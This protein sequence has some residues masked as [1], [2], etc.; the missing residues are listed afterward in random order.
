MNTTSSQTPKYLSS[1]G[2]VDSINFL[3]PT[4]RSHKKQA[5]ESAIY[6]SGSSSTRNLN[7]KQ[8]S[9][10][11]TVMEEVPKLQDYMDDL[12]KTWNLNIDLMEN[13]VEADISLYNPELKN[14]PDAVKHK[15]I[16]SL[17]K[18]I[19]QLHDKKLSM[20]KKTLTLR[21]KLLLDQQIEEEVKKTLFES[22]K[23]YFDQEKELEDL[24]L[25]KE[26]I[27][28][29]NEKKFNEVEIYI[30]RECL[31]EE[32]KKYHKYKDFFV[33]PF[34]RENQE[35]S[36]KR[37]LL[38]KYINTKLNEV[39]DLKQENSRLITGDTPKKHEELL[40]QSNYNNVNRVIK[41]H[42]SNNSFAVKLPI[43]TP[44]SKNCKTDRKNITPNSKQF[45]SGLFYK[46]THNNKFKSGENEMIVLVKKQKKP[47]HERIKELLEKKILYMS[48]L[49]EQFKFSLNYYIEKE[50]LLKENNFLI[51]ALINKRRGE[52]L[53]KQ[54]NMEDTG[55]NQLDLED[56]EKQKTIS[57]TDDQQIKSSVYDSEKTLFK[58]IINDE[59]SIILKIQSNEK[60]ISQIADNINS[61]SEKPLMNMDKGE[62]Y[63]FNNMNNEK[64][65]DNYIKDNIKENINLNDISMNTTVIYHNIN[66]KPCDNN[67]TIALEESFITKDINFNTNNVNNADDKWDISV[68]NTNYYDN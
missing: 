38:V 67:L 36:Y 58:S 63:T 47:K 52:G 17:I 39:E 27:V 11:L 24:C 19:K 3:D 68:I 34:I 21:S 43:D 32:N 53:N 4:F 59:E 65:N 12:T 5:S 9:K 40:D 42:K 6:C 8:I 15:E 50:K 35:H 31:F 57:M 29:Q 37:F 62:L 14:N 55:L 23:G 41:Q 46:E 56:K 20:F 25:K 45:F 66:E 7:A 61:Y 44:T 22:E 48:S 13:M 28:A 51:Q 49:N 30:Q 64:G 2:T 18:S 10:R 1:R 54:K 26:N 60:R 16:V 33:V